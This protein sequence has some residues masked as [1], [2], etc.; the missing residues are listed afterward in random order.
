MSLALLAPSRCAVLLG[1]VQYREFANVIEDSTPIENANFGRF[2][3]FSLARIGIF[4]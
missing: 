4:L 2:G 3:A 1:S